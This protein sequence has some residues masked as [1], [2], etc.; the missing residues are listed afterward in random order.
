MAGTA[1]IGALGATAWVG[2]LLYDF[3]RLV[4]DLPPGSW[5]RPMGLSVHLV[6]A[7]YGSI[8]VLGL[9]AVLGIV[10]GMRCGNKFPLIIAVVALPLSG[11]PLIGGWI[12]F[13]RIIDTRGLI[14]SD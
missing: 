11:V 8:L 4:S 9:V 1:L 5:V 2:W 6:L 3:D 10:R 7:G 14:L 12:G 13:D